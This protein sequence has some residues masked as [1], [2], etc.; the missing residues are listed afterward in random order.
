M[1]CRWLWRREDS[2]RPQRCFD[3]RFEYVTR[4]IG[5]ELGDACAASVAFGAAVCVRVGVAVS[6]RAAVSV[7]VG[8]AIGV[9]V[10]V[11][12]EA[13]DA[14]RSG[15]AGNEACEASG[16]VCRTSP[17]ADSRSEPF[18]APSNKPAE[19]KVAAIATAATRGMVLGDAAMGPIPPVFGSSGKRRSN[20]KVGGGGVA[21]FVDGIRG[22]L[23]PTHETKVCKASSLLG[24]SRVA[25]ASKLSGWSSCDLSRFKP[26][27][28]SDSLPRFHSKPTVATAPNRHREGYL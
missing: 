11:A 13:S 12:N 16:S 26:F 7:R 14:P 28:S 21:F 9:R 1:L 23:A 2:I 25:R 20:T 5:A 10:G 6:V 19:K 3:G 8:V 24:E 27:R 17:A 22:F 18:F 4:T 15:N